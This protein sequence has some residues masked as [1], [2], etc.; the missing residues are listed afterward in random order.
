[1]LHGHSWFNELSR[2]PELLQACI[3]SFSQSGEDIVVNGLLS[4][5][6]T[7]GMVVDLGAYHPYRFSNTFALYLEG[8]RGLN[9]DANP[10]AVELCR[11]VRTEDVSVHALLSDKVEELKYFL[12][13][14]GAWNTTDEA[15]AL[16][17]LAR[18]P[19]PTKLMRVD[20]LFTRQANELF[21]EYVADRKFDFLNI[22]I[23]GMDSRVLFSIDFHKYRPR[24]I[25]IEFDLD[26]W[27]KDDARLFLSTYGYRVVSVCMHTS[28]LVRD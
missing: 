19:P 17:L 11:Q 14:E 20:K 26:R 4:R 21:A 9:V 8:W 5:E 13:E 18:T 28:I 10:Q 2:Y 15:A 24:V 1:M 23:E 16:D 27:K 22:D 25:A 3:V 7:K 12:F 6:S